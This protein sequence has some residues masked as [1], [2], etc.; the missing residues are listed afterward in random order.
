MVVIH[1]FE[2]S[3]LHNLLS[4]NALFSDDKNSFYFNDKDIDLKN[5]GFFSLKTAL[6][7]FQLSADKN[8]AWVMSNWN[9]PPDS[10]GTGWGQIINN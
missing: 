4:K 5:V 3:I 1:I 6:E 2:F 8:I 10:F 9:L 7:S